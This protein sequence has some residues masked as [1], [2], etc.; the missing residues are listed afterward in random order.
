MIAMIELRDLDKVAY[1]RYASVYKDFREVDAFV[2]EIESLEN[3][4]PL[5]AAPATEAA[6]PTPAST[7]LG[8][9]Q[10][11]HSGEGQ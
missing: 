6:A 9:K 4:K 10:T 2:E 8:T 7:A 1:I 11:T 3:G 5:M